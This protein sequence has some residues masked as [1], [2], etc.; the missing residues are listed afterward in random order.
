MGTL[1]WLVT[2]AHIR[3]AAPVTSMKEKKAANA[4]LNARLTTNGTRV[5]RSDLALNAI[6]VSSTSDVCQSVV[7]PAV[8]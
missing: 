4:V 8:Y 3:L 6:I 1:L 2:S 5:R 7:N